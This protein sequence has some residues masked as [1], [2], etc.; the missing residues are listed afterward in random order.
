MSPSSPGLPHPRAA[1]LLRPG[2]FAALRRS[3]KRVAL[4]HFHC[5]F[6]PNAGATARLGMA[7]SRRVS[8]LAV[9]RN[10]IRRQIRESFRLRR[11]GLPACDVLVIARVSTAE[12]SNAALREELDE[13]WR[14]L[15]ARAA[16]ASAAELLNAAEAPGT[17]RDR[18]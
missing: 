5:E 6:R 14:K 9:V 15:S 4:K 13:L 3:G 2:D 8:K 1:R 7:V 11:P 16:D 17:M 18:L 10:R 12:L